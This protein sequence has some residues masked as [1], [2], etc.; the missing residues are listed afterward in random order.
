MTEFLPSPT[1]LFILFAGAVAAFVWYLIASR[2]RTTALRRMGIVED[3][4]HPAEIDDEPLGVGLERWLGLAGYRGPTAPAMFILATIFCAGLGLF[5]MV[6]LRATGAFASMEEGLVSIPGNFGEVLLPLLEAM[7]W[8]IFLYF[9]GLPALVVRGRRRARM[10]AAERELP[11]LLELLSTLAQAGLG[12]DAAINE[13]LDSE[14]GQGYIPDELRL[15]QRETFS[16]V[17]RMRCLRRLARRVDVPAF[18]TFVSVLIQAERSGLGLTDVL[19]VQAEDM[20]NRRR[21][22]ALAKAQA[23]PVKLVFPLVLCFL[24]ALFVLT[25]GPAFLHFFQIADTVTGNIRR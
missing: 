14:H 19:R 21:E 15:F 1:V 20:R 13:I 10:D 25:L 23:L 8:L 3:D 2:R 11:V 22:N 7:P 9:A 18:S 5:F 24:P 6:M 16:G 12:L 4:A 17:P